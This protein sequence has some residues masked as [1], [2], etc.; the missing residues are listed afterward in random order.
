MKAWFENLAVR[1]QAIVAAGAIIALLI[2]AWGLIWTPLSDGTDE[3]RQSVADRTRLLSDLRRAERLAAT[4]S[5]SGTASAG[6]SILLIIDNSARSFGLAES[7]TQTRPNG[8]DEISVSFQRAPFDAIVAWLIELESSFGI[9]AGTV[10]INQTG[11]PGLVSGQIFLV[12][13]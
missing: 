2:V 1:E 11:Q 8:T 13:G 9:S 6:Q 7:F 12:R 4:D 5:G 3:L 10:S